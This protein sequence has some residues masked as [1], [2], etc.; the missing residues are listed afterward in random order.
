MRNVRR[1]TGN[2]MHRNYN[3]LEHSYM[4]VVLFMEFCRREDITINL[5]CIDLV[6]HHDIVET[7]TSDLPYPVKNYNTKTQTCWEEM[8]NE[9]LKEHPCLTRYSDARIKQLLPTKAYELFKVCDLLELWICMSE[10]VALGNVSSDCMQVIHKCNELIKGN[11]ES[12][13]LFMSR[14]E[15]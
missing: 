4:V 11:F 1:L 7:V 9:I 8:E 15:I 3:L 2:M 12:V 5:A 6:L 10:E 14:Y 13:D